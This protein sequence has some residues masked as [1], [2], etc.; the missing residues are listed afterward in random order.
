[1][2]EIFKEI[3]MEKDKCIQIRSLLSFEKLQHFQSHQQ[4]AWRKL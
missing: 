3:V 2:L 4:D 1:M